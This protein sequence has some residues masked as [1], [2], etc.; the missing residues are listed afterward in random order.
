MS[1]PSR[2]LEVHIIQFGRFLRNHGFIIGPG[3]HLEA[4]A[5]LELIGFNQMPLFEQVLA[6]VFCKS[7]EQQQEFGALF[8]EFWLELFQ[9]FDSKVKTVEVAKSPEA[10]LQALKSWLYQNQSQNKDQEE[11]VMHSSAL[12]AKAVM[13]SYQQ[14]Q[15]EELIRLLN[16]FTKDWA[17][18]PTRRY[19]TKSRLGKLDLRKSIRQNAGQFDL[20][21]LLYRKRKPRKLDLV[22]LADSSRSMELFSSF[23]MQLLYA[24]QQSYRRLETFVFGTQLFRITHWMQEHSFDKA[25]SKLHQQIPEWSGGTKIGASL[26]QFIT[27]YGSQM[28][29]NNCLLLIISDGWDTGDQE[30]LEW[31]TRYLQRRTRKLI[32]LNPHASKP[33]YEPLV[34]GMQTALPYIDIFQG[35]HDI[36]SFKSWQSSRYQSL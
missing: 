34:S 3:E 27:R 33:G 21:N 11:L 20:V 36:E 1:N 23:T 25:V 4:S 9:A 28:L 15:V 13:P 19:Q 22:V 30:Q 26:S 29:H 17:N 8:M 16:K 5:A 7:R 14:Q 35:V 31:A 12:A 24:F 2:A 32:W 10:H 18:R 6:T